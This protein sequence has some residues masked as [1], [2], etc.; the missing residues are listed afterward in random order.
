LDDLGRVGLSGVKLRKV[1][2]TRKE[3]TEVETRGLVEIPK[4]I[5]YPIAQIGYLG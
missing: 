3:A 4:S 1:G 2:S 5:P